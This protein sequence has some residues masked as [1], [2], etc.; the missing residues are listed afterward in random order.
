MLFQREWCALRPYAFFPF[1]FYLYSVKVISQRLTGETARAG[2]MRFSCERGLRVEGKAK[3]D[4]VKVTER[5]DGRR[6]R[7]KEGEGKKARGE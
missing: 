1:S 6:E 5:Q 2:L 7:R 4:R 3:K